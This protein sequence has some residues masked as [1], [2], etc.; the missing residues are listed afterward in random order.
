M[1]WNVEC[2]AIDLLDARE[3][4]GALRQA[5]EVANEHEVLDTGVELRQHS[6]RA[7]R[8]EHHADDAECYIMVAG[9]DLAHLAKER[10]GGVQRQSLEVGLADVLDLQ[11]DVSDVASA[12]KFYHVAHVV[13]LEQQVSQAHESASANSYTAQVADVVAIHAH[14][15]GAG[16]HRHD[17]ELVEAAVEACPQAVG[18]ELVGLAGGQ[19][20]DGSCHSR[21]AHSCEHHVL[22]VVESDSVVVDILSKRP[23]ERC[24]GVGCG[25]KH[26]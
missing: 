18:L 2:H 5:R 14:Q 12:G 4:H 20:V 1:G 22:N 9:G 26:G 21:A 8:L 25:D 15:R 6:G 11:V 23:K 10:R 24:D 17:G 16:A 19:V 13:G 7:Y 3:H